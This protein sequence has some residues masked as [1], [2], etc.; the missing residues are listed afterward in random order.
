MAIRLNSASGR[1]LLKHRY[2]ERVAEL[3]PILWIELVA[4]C[5]VGW[6]FGSWRTTVIGYIVTM[7]VLFALHIWDEYLRMKRERRDTLLRR[8]VPD[9]QINLVSSLKVGFAVK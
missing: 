5:L 8:G 7:P 6:A 1:S 4:W 2:I 9:D 3:R